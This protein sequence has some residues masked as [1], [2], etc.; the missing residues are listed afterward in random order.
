MKRVL[1]GLMV[2]VLISL[3]YKSSY[4]AFFKQ[5]NYIEQNQWGIL[6]D[7]MTD[8]KANRITTDEC[9]IYGCYALAALEPSRADRNEKSKL[10]PSKYKFEKKS[11]SCNPYFFVDF[12]YDNEN[13]LG[14]KA[15]EEFRKSDWSD[16]QY[17]E[18]FKNDEKILKTIEATT[19]EPTFMRNGHAFRSLLDTIRNA[20]NN[21]CVKREAAYLIGFQVVHFNTWFENRHNHFL[22]KYELG[23][24][25]IG[26]TWLSFQAN[27][28]TP[29]LIKSQNM[30]IMNLINYFHDARERRKYSLI[31]NIDE[32]ECY[33]DDKYLFKIKGGTENERK[34]I[35]EYL[36]KTYKL[37]C[38]QKDENNP[39]KF[40]K[41]I[42]FEKNL[43]IEYSKSLF[44]SQI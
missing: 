32:T 13:N 43:P 16:Y 17:I 22:S 41:P 28:L 12:L 11:V 6:E 14:A 21:G 25:E 8:Y 10:L 39:L 42:N 44:H 31:T 35:K 37:M 40:K 9:A 18:E 19:F 5:G 38:N 24:S 7:I 1:F 29:A 26:V 27:V 15:L 2:V 3:T 33:T 23:I 4:A 34:I 30:K 20:T 36:P